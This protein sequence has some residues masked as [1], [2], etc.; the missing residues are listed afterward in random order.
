MAASRTYGIGGIPATYPSFKSVDLRGDKAEISFNNAD[1]GLNPNMNLQ[2]FEV[3]G[4]DHIFYPAQASEDWNKRTVTVSSDKVRDIKA[5]RYCFN[6]FAI[7]TL[8]DMNGMPLIPFRT[9]DW[10]DA[11][12]ACN[13]AEK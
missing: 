1:A 9:D 12:R 11:R 6:N 10:T 2:G 8:K 13:I 5:V 3:A 4:D 7:G